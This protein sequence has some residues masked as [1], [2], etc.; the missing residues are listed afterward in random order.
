MQAE[1]GREPQISAGQQTS[2]V[3]R[4]MSM[5]EEGRKPDG[6]AT[7]RESRARPGPA[8]PWNLIIMKSF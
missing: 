8:R 3:L 6:A 4:G 1:S 7:G 5:A 2:K